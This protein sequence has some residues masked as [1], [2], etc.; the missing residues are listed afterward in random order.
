MVR[1]HLDIGEGHTVVTEHYA[2]DAGRVGHGETL[3]VQVPEHA[4]TLF[5]SA[6]AL[7]GR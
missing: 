4:I 1:Y 7:V 6:G 5:D 2:S 3:T